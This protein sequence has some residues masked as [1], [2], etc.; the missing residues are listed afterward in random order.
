VDYVKAIPL[1]IAL[2]LFLYDVRTKNLYR[3][4]AVVLVLI[5][6]TYVAWMF[7]LSSWWQGIGEFTANNLF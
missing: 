1:A 3:T 6:F 2:T 5:T 4:N 7:R